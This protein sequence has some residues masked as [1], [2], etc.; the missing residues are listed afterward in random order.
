VS[1]GDGASAWSQ[2]RTRPSRNET[3][4]GTAPAIADPGVLSYSSPSPAAESRGS[5]ASNPDS[6]RSRSGFSNGAVNERSYETRSAP[7]SRI[8]E[9]S[10]RGDSSR[11]VERDP[12]RTT[13]TPD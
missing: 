6:I 5:R 11:S 9:G 2:S 7:V 3:S 13:Q 4:R 12:G 1:S 8:A 10:P